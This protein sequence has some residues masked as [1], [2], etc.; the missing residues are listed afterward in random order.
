MIQL[1]Q[2]QDNTAKVKGWHCLRL[3]NF[4]EMREGMVKVNLFEPEVELPPYDMNRA[5][6]KLRD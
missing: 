3:T 4:Q 6:G 2:K 5:K 1:M